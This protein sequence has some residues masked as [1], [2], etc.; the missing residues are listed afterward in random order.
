MRYTASSVG[1]STPLTLLQQNLQLWF[2]VAFVERV[3]HYLIEVNSGR[4][5]VG[6]KRYL[7]LIEQRWPGDGQAPVRA[8]QAPPAAAEPVKQVTVTLLGQVERRQVQPDQRLPG[9][10]AGAHRRLAG[11]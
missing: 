3:G 4:L 1:V 9:R 8:E 7:Q 5:R 6:V 10:A 2:Y 11:H